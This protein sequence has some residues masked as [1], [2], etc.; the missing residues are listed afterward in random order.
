MPYVLHTKTLFFLYQLSDTNSSL[1]VNLNRRCSSHVDEKQ[2]ND[3]QSNNS[4]QYLHTRTLVEPLSRDLLY[5]MIRKKGPL[6]TKHA[7]ITTSQLIEVNEMTIYMKR[8]HM[9]QSFDNTNCSI[10]AMLPKDLVFL[11]HHLHG[12]NTRSCNEH[13]TWLEIRHL[14]H[15]QCL[16]QVCTKELTANYKTMHYQVTSIKLPKA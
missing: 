16:Q 10:L 7:N 9:K 13:Y 5:H 8:H 3:L 12:L 15:L 6:P 11:I 14:Y 1:N 2:V 4:T